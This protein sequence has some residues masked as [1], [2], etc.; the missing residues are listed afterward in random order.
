[1][2]VRCPGASQRKRILPF[3]FIDSSKTPR[4]LPSDKAACFVLHLVLDYMMTKDNRAARRHRTREAGHHACVRA[5]ARL[6]SQHAR[7]TRP[8]RQKTCSNPCLPTRHC[9]TNGNAFKL[10]KT[11][12]SGH[13]HSTLAE[14]LAWRQ[15]PGGNHPRNGFG[16]APKVFYNRPNP[17]EGFQREGRIQTC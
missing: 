11:H 9:M 12:E 4:Q 7:F 6:R 1:M 3:V 10:L 17:I 2:R 5:T 8:N 16:R 15:F 13:A 14:G